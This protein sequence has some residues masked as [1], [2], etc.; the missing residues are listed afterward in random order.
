MIFFTNYPRVL[1]E[2]VDVVLDIFCREIMKD[3]YSVKGLKK[4]SYLQKCRENM[5]NMVS[6]ILSKPFAMSEDFC[7][8]GNIGQV[9]Y[10]LL[11]VM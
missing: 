1:K 10:I 6:G 2:L 8:L 7:P 9:A 3:R 4:S 5:Q 11:W